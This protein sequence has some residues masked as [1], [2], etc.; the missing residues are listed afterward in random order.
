MG[1]LPHI[2]AAS[3]GRKRCPLQRLFAKLV[4]I[5]ATTIP[6]SDPHES[7]IVATLSPGSYTAIVRGQNG[8]TGV[9]LVEV[10]NLD[11]ESSSTP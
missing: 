9:A 4:A 10:Y 2:A 5:Q 7:A 3:T 8:G 11:Y 6:P 1:N